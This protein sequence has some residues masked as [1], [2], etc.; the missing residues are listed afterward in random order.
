M[1]W[2]CAVALLGGLIVLPA[3]GEDLVEINGK[4]VLSEK[5]KL[6]ARTPLVFDKDKA[7][8]AMDKDANTE[9]W[10]IDAKTR[11]IRDVVV[12]IVAEPTDEQAKA[13]A[14]DKG[15]AKVELVF[16][17]KLI[18]AKLKD[19]PKD[20]VVF[21]QPC[22][23]YIPHVAVARVG[24]KVTIKNSA[25]IPHNAQWTSANNGE[26]NPLLAAGGKKEVDPLV[27]ERNVITLGCTIHPWMKAFLKVVDS[28][29][30]AVTDEKGEFKIKDIPPGKYR[31]VYFHPEGG[32]L[33]GALGRFGVPLEVKAKGGAIPATE[34]KIEEPK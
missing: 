24:Q 26:F 19:V 16:D 29:Y 9:N 7:V 8:C 14:K 23:R 31:I 33:D 11:A 30:Y 17:P 18:P 22:C 2:F 3:M 27:A 25:S 6:P 10:V 12:Y 15:R 5:S 28:P 4:V 21:D 13:I 34:W 32:F 20:P 1:R